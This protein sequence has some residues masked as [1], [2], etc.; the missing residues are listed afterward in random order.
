MVR[1]I[2]HRLQALVPVAVRLVVDAPAPLVLHDVALVVELLL[3]HRGQQPAHAGRTRARARA[4][5]SARAAS[6]SSWCGRARSSRSASRPPS[7]CSAK[8]AISG[9]FAEP[10]NIMCSKRCAKPVRPARSF[11]EPDVVPEV[12]RDDGRAR[13]ARQDDAQAV[14]QPVSL[15]RDLDMRPS[16]PPSPTAPARLRA[17]AAAPRSPRGRRR[18]RSSSCAGIQVAGARPLHVRLPSLRA[19]ARTY[20][21]K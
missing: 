2:H 18:S 7:R 1:R 5:G 9:T 11:R 4:R 16:S 20:S 19:P 12:H 21:S 8:C 13:V 3:R 10:W 17:R 6:R 14:V 15:E